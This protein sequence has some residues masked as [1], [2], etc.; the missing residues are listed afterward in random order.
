MN[1]NEINFQHD[2][3]DSFL[4]RCMNSTK[5]NQKIVDSCLAASAN[6][7]EFI[8]S[9][10]AHTEEIGTQFYAELVERERPYRLWKTIRECLGERQ[11]KTDSDAGSVRIG[12]ATF[13]MLV[14][15]GFGDGISRVAVFDD[16]D[17]FNADSLLTFFTIVN[18]AFNVYAYDCGGE[19]TVATLDGK[20]AIY[21][22][23]GFVAFVRC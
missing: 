13:T 5:T 1:R 23:K 12:N 4:T 17:D 9:Y 21:Y 7:D 8:D 11:F 6:T 15:N 16:R 14:P 3:I 18:G 20:Y 10:L 19:E 2:G 22:G